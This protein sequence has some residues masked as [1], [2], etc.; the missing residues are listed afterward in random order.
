MQHRHVTMLRG[1][2]RFR[3][4][5][6]VLAMLE[7]LLLL[8]RALRSQIDL[9]P[10]LPLVLL[11]GAPF[12]TRS[13]SDCYGGLTT[14]EAGAS[15]SLRKA[16]AVEGSLSDLICC[17]AALQRGSSNTFLS[18]HILQKPFQGLPGY[19]TQHQPLDDTTVKFPC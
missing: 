6:V 19:Q 5:L 9:T 17:S 11:F 4:Y 2:K 18:Q 8:L 14:V 15:A 13:L 10:L 16:A 12:D 7:E 1:V 3:L